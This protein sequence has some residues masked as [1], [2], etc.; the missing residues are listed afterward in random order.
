MTE[1]LVER[2]EDCTLPAGEFHHEQHVFVA[3][4]YVRSMPLSTALDRFCVNL[5]RFATAAGAA[6]L[7]HET[8]TWAFLI[9]T[10]ERMERAPDAGWTEFKSAN[11][12]LFSWK[13]SILDRYYSAA[14]LWSDTA[15]RTFVFPDISSYEALR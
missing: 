3:W 1:H 6:G 4:S 12:E 9:L 13:P 15:R 5:K 14:T 10:H 8:I 11:P 7:Y 2:F